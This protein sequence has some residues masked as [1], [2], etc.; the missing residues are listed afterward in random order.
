MRKLM[1]LGILLFAVSAG[2]V[3][4]TYAADSSSSLPT[5][6]TYSKEWINIHLLTWRN[7]SKVIVLDQYANVRA[8]NIK[9][10]AD[11]NQ[12]DKIAG[13]TGRYTNLSAKI[14]QML[15]QKGIADRA[16]LVQTVS[17]DTIKQQKIISLARQNV[18][19]DN[20]KTLLASVQEQV[21]NQTKDMISSAVDENSAND[22]ADNIVSAWRDPSGSVADEKATRVYAA[23]T[24]ASTNVNDGVIIDNGEA[25]ISQETGG[26]LK[27]EYAPGTGPSSATGGDGKKVWKIELSD[28]TSVGSYSVAS[29]VVVGGSPSTASNVTVENSVTAAVNVAPTVA[30]N[31]TGEA[32]VTIVGGK[33]KV[34]SAPMESGGPATDPS[35][36][37]KNGLNSVNSINQTNSTDGQGGGVQQVAPMAPQ[38]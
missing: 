30:G 7:S 19:D 22:F 31:N 6:W 21:V 2:G 18:G 1:I 27:I 25:K 13:L 28:G 12:T 3:C 24:V 15:E 5:Q 9:S 17:A 37:P 34:V 11:L 4:K 16:T 8:N 10:A 20:A 32:K 29:P 33:A 36:T 14:N 35:T 38:P 26:G 23:G